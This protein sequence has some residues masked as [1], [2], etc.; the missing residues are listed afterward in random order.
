MN[1]LKAVFWD[2]PR[3]TDPDDLRV[4]IKNNRHSEKVYLWIMKRFLEN[5]RVIDTLRFFPLSEIANHITR[6]RLS[7]YAKRKW[8]RIIEFYGET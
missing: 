8:L 4:F 3:L 1:T 6:L 7:G 5:G 2:Y